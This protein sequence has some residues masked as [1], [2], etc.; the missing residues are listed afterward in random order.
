MKKEII[1]DLIKNNNCGRCGEEMS[2]DN[3][4]VEFGKYRGIESVQ[5]ALCPSYAIVENEVTK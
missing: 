2:K 1:R 3:I 4:K 5:H